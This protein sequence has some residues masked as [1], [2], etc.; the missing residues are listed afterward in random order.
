M[1]TAQWPGLPSQEFPG[2]HDA[3][4]TEGQ[5]VGYRYYVGAIRVLWNSRRQGLPIYSCVCLSWVQDKQNIKPAW[6]FGHGLTYGNSTYSNLKVMGR[7]ISF[8]LTITGGCDTPQVY[9]SYPNAATDPTVPSKVLRAFKK[10]CHSDVLVVRQPLTTPL[11]FTLTDRDVSEWD[12]QAKAW[13]ITPGKFKVSVGTSSQDIRLSGVLT[14][15]HSFF[16]AS[17]TSSR[18]RIAVV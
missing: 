4:Y 17:H 15:A 3:H 12:T 18:S 16:G 8:D 1:T 2:H 10:T 14:V 7:T 11:S 9:I 5:I 6:P 13:R